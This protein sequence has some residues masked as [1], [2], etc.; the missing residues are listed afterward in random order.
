MM[1]DP[2]PSQDK[3]AAR[4]AK[5]LIVDD[6][7]DIVRLLSFALQA[8]GYQVVTALSGQEALKR[9]EQERPDIVVLDVMMPGMDGIEVCA[10]LRSKPETAGLPIIMLSALGQVAD[11][12]RGLRAGA[13]DYVP[14]PVTITCP[15]PSIWRSC[16]RASR[17]S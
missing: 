4:P 8:E 13:D 15:S 10:E 2:K 14:K 7:Q 11:R 17:R 5:I 12:V 9:V 6:E 1:A 3:S 16:R